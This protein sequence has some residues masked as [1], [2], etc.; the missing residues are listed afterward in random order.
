M[1]FMTAFKIP[2]CM[3]EVVFLQ[4]HSMS[5]FTIMLNFFFI[6]HNFLTYEKQRKWFN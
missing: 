5:S 6:L 2:F 1:F 3:G 4:F